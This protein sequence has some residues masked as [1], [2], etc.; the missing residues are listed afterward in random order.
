LLSVSGR[1]AK[2]VA[3]SPGQFWRSILK[4][5]SQAHLDLLEQALARQLPFRHL[6]IAILSTKTGTPRWIHIN[7]LPV[8]SESGA[9]MG[10]RG[11]ATDITRA[12]RA[13]ALLYNYN[14]ELLAEVAQQTLDLRQSHSDLIIKEQHLQ[15]ILAAVPVGVLELDDAD[16]C[17]YLNVNGGSLTGCAPEQAQ[18]AH[19]L[20]FVHPDDCAR[21]EHAW[22]S[23]RQDQQVQWLEFRLNHSNL[24]CVAYWIHLRHADQTLDGSIM[25]LADSTAR[26]QQDERLWTLAHHDPLTHLPNRNLFWD[27]CTQA[28]SLAKRRET[29]AAMLWIDLDGFKSVN[30]RLGHAAG[31]ALL[32]QVAQ[33]L[34]GRIRDSDTV[35]RM[36]GDEFAVIMPDIADAESAVQVANELLASLDAIFE[37]PQGFIHISGSIGV[38][39]FPQHAR[40]VETLTQ[41]ADMAMYRA[42]HAG[43]NQVQVWNEHC[44]QPLQASHLA[45]S[46]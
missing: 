17:R 30:D 40:S 27:R 2:L 9:L 19:F 36:G 14:Q 44:H 28:V 37:L 45:E 10:F 31:D 46:N 38:A 3:L 42:K 33:R 34:K 13:K 32:Q 18:G 11:T 21:V 12:H 7:G 20:A 4:D 43:K 6:E 23:H 25:V 16:C 29:G 41:Y 22:N 26:R 8:R 1:L 5:V 35:A 15:V 39:L 24:W